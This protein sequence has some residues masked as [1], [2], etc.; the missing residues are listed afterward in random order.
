MVLSWP[1]S[2]SAPRAAGWRSSG[3]LAGARGA[4]EGTVM[5]PV[6][7]QPGQRDEHLARI[8]DISAVP[9]IAQR[10]GPCH[11]L[12]KP[13]IPG[14]RPDVAVRRQRV[15]VGVPVGVRVGVRDRG[16]VGNGS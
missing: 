3:I 13:G 14:Q 1:S 4:R 6:A 16:G 12:C 8:G 5:A 9:G 7:A 10:R 11:Q 2:A 15:R